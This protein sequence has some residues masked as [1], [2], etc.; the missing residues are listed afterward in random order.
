MNLKKFIATVI[1][2]GYHEKDTAS[3]PNNFLA[4][5]LPKLNDNLKTNIE[6]IHHKKPDN[7]DRDSVRNS[8]LSNLQG[9]SIITKIFM[10]LNQDIQTCI[11]CY[12]S[13][14]IKCMYS[15]SMDYKFVVDLKK[16]NELK[17]SKQLEKT[18]Y[19]T[20]DECLYQQ[21]KP[22]SV[23]KMY[24]F[25]C[26]R[27]SIFQINPSIDISPNVLILSL[28]R[29]QN[30]KCDVKVDF[31]EY[32]DITN[33]LYDKCNPQ[34]YKLYGVITQI[35]NNANGHFIASCRSPID[36]QWYKYNDS[37]VTRIND[38][39]KEVANFGTTYILFYEK[40]TN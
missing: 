7:Y 9:D 32:L 28:T 21:L 29:N 3:D 18:N 35:G 25:K 6:P 40:V 17:N 38:F 8:Y 11:N 2:L 34:R 36:D 22:T 26:R 5:F 30:E 4:D 10:H 16:A 14:N 27:E 37:I 31:G 33:F 12:N 15:Y 19:V 20:L 1:K 23:E 24:C 13:G 39:A